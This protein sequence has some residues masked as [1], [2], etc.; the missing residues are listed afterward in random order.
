MAREIVVLDS[1]PSEVN[2]LDGQTYFKA[3]DGTLLKPGEFVIQ[4]ALIPA[5]VGT[6]LGIA[7][8]AS[9]EDS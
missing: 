3:A 4:L 2:G 9:D 8:G 5:E 1:V 6:I 7:E